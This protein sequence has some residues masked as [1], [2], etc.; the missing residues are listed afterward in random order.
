MVIMFCTGL[1]VCTCTCIYCPLFVKGISLVL[2][3]NV[4]E[5]RINLYGLTYQFMCIPVC[6]KLSMFFSNSLQPFIV[7]EFAPYSL[8]HGELFLMQFNACVCHANFKALFLFDD[9]NYSLYV[10]QLPYSRLFQQGLI[11]CAACQGTK[12]R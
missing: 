10:Q 6:L 4:E 3:K 11:F 7:L 2:P 12:I 9:S 5:I 8:E 1:V